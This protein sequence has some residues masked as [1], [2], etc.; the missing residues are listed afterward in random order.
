MPGGRRKSLLEEVLTS[1]SACA[2]ALDHKKL[3]RE[4]QRLSLSRRRRSSLF[5]S[6]KDKENTRAQH[7]EIQGRVKFL[8]GE[9]DDARDELRLAAE[10]GQTLL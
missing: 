10:I 9:L 8:E 3:A 7:K 2:N 1:T 5:P 6:L 4:E